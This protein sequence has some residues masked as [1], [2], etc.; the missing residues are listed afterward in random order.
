[1]AR[2]EKSE[3]SIP[4]RERPFLSFRDVG[5]LLAC[6]PN[7][8]YALARAGKLEIVHVL[9]DASFKAV[10]TAGVAA[11]VDAAQPWTPSGRTPEPYEP[12]IEAAE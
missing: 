7:Y 4:W 5:G 1:M 8:V 11:L 9:P 6:H 12:V 2:F 10:R 3:P